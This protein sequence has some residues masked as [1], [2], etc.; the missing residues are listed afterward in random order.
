MLGQRTMAWIDRRCR[1]AT[2]KVNHFFGGISI[3]L[4]GD[5]AQLPPVADK[6][7]YLSVPYDSLCEEGDYAYL[8]FEKF[9]TLDATNVVATMI[10]L[11]QGSL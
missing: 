7:L 6:P 4:V 5:P 2:G 11:I 10:L 9:I 3:V 1:E 8:S